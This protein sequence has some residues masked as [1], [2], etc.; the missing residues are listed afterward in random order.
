MILAD[1]IINERKKNG[2]SQEELANMLSVSRQSIS[3]WEGAQA[4]PDLQKILKM[5][6]VFNVSTDYLLKDELEPEVFTSSN[7]QGETAKEDIPVRTVTLEEANSF[8]KLENRIAPIIANAVSLCIISPALLIFL[9]ALS[10]KGFLS[11]EL[12]AGI[13]LVSLLIL[14]AVAVFMFITSGSKTKQYEYLE[15]EVIETSYGVT[16]MVKEKQKAYNQ[17]H[18]SYIALGVMLCILSVIP[19]FL[20]LF[21][22]GKND[23]FVAAAV[24]LILIIVAIGVNLI[25]RTSIISSSF[26][27]LLQENDYSIQTKKDN[28]VLEPIAGIYWTLTVAGY[29]AWS[30]ITDRWDLTWIVWPIAGILYGVLVSVVKIIKKK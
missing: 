20:A 28:A 22:F 1:K 3:K 11:E 24:S 14:V 25:V 6:E 27:K 9:A 5:A 30:F 8:L 29:L 15:K 23:S 13:G 18:S 17:T 21:L 10:Q 4:V 16:G 19:F 26:N 2:W 12:A 7:Y